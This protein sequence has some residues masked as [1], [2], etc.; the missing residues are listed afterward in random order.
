MDGQPPQRPPQQQFVISS[1]G[2][3]QGQMQGQRFAQRTQIMYEVQPME[4]GGENVTYSRVQSTQQ[5]HPTVSALLRHGMNPAPQVQYSQNNPPPTQQ[6]MQTTVSGVPLVI[7]GNQQ[8]QIVTSTQPQQIIISQG[9]RP[10]MVQYIQTSSAGGHQPQYATIQQHL[11]SSQNQPQHVFIQQQPQQQQQ[12]ILVQAQPQTQQIHYAES[13]GSQGSSAAPPQQYAY[14]VPMR[15]PPEGQKIS[16][17]QPPHHMIATGTPQAH[18][19]AAANNI[20]QEEINRFLMSHQSSSQSMSTGQLL[21]TAKLEDIAKQVDATANLDDG[22]KDALVSYIDEY[23]GMVIEKSAEVARHR[24]AR[25]IEHKDV[26]YALRNFFDMG[27]LATQSLIAA[28]N[29][30]NPPTVQDVMNQSGP[31]PSM[32]AHNQRLA[33]IKKTLKKP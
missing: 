1:G 28:D 14:A 18:P 5:Q 27:D 10:Q 2:N 16:P 7:S 22:V 29:H 32:N 24:G 12:H 20:A 15:N 23:I 4:E 30:L 9:G 31:S 6:Q 21:D 3:Q 33:L 8:P 11:Q 19:R 25:R 13:S 17:R 26:A